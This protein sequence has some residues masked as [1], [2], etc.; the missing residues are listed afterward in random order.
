MLYKNA[1]FIDLCSATLHVDDRWEVF[2]TL[3]STTHHR[4]VLK[5]SIQAASF[6]KKRESN[7]WSELESM[8]QLHIE[9]AT[10]P[11]NSTV[12]I[13]CLQSS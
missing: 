10:A 13:I 11:S 9:S 7:I 8:F 4:C 12:G 2:W 5:Q 1:V 3:K 6:R